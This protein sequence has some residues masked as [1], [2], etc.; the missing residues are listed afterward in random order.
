MRSYAELFMV[1]IKSVKMY[2]FSYGGFFC[3]WLVLLFSITVK[4]SDTTNQQVMFYAC[5]GAKE[6]H[7]CMQT[8]W[9]YSQQNKSTCPW[10]I[11]LVIVCLVAEQPL[12][13]RFLLCHVMK[14]CVRYHTK[15]DCYYN[16][17]TYCQSN[18]HKLISKWSCRPTVIHSYCLLAFQSSTYLVHLKLFTVNWLTS[19]WRQIRNLF[20]KILHWTVVVLFLMVMCFFCVGAPDGGVQHCCSGVEAE[21][22]RHVW[23][24]QKQC[25]DERILS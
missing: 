17:G 9:W 6:K 13:G 3:I 12:N 7:F 24:G 8:L 15:P 18:N 25:V 22:L 14:L 11:L 1:C 5:P 4:N 20:L 21:L 19:V 2:L 23:A 16:Y 10:F